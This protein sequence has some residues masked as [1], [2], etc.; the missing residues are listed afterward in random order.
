MARRR[1]KDASGPSL[2]DGPHGVIRLPGQTGPAVAIGTEADDG[3][4]AYN[5]DANG[6]VVIH[7]ALGLMDPW[8]GLY[9]SSI[10]DQDVVVG[11][12]RAMVA[13]YKRLLKFAGANAQVLYRGRSGTGKDVLARAAAAVAGRRLVPVDTPAFAHALFES[14]LFGHV[15]GAF[16]GADCDRRGWLDVEE[17]TL[18]L[19]KEIGDLD[20][21]L[22][23][24]LRRFIETRRF[25]RVGEAVVRETKAS[26]AFATNQDLEQL[27]QEGKFRKDLYYRITTFRITLPPLSARDDDPLLLAVYFVR[28][29]DTHGH[30]ITMIERD[31]V[32][33][34]RHHPWDGNVRE[35]EGVIRR[36]LV[37]QEGTVLRLES[38]LGEE[39][40]AQSEGH[41][42]IRTA[43]AAPSLPAHCPFHLDALSLLEYWRLARPT[44]PVDLAEG[45]HVSTRTVQRLVKQLLEQ[46]R[47]VQ[48]RA[49][50]RFYYT[51]A[52]AVGE[53]PQDPP[54]TAGHAVGPRSPG[55]PPHQGALAEVLQQ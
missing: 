28:K 33:W 1:K 46:E 52:P 4:T 55:T 13:V 26:F 14:E 50:R 49:G 53:P 32:E 2:L 39:V 6:N 16:T 45:C 37:L 42:P 48:L 30:K 18:V 44:T 43:P 25:S 10:S 20:W 22:Q 5:I 7:R 35:I 38:L 23:A 40:P 34:I 29:H 17:D 51:Y 54:A 24:K 19:I 3:K 47:V 12:S 27:V 9:F 41:G 36:A 11:R 31:A 21:G 8:W 15:R